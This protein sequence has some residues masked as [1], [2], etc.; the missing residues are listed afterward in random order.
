MTIAEF[1]SLKIGQK[2][3]FEG[4]KYTV[5]SIDKQRYMVG[6]SFMDWIPY[7]EATICKA[8]APITQKV[9]IQFCNGTKTLASARKV[10][11]YLGVTPQALG[12]ALKRNSPL[13]IQVKVIYKND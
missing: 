3:Y 13:N 7:K 5:Y 12:R 2:V 10:A 8:T 1:H 6:I 11:D 9:Q 4:D